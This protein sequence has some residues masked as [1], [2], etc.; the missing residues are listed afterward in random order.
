LP[1]ANDVRADGI[2]NVGQRQASTL[3]GLEKIARRM[4]LS[5][6][7]IFVHELPPTMTTR[8]TGMQN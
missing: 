4:D 8:W 7:R 5:F 6:K 1:E 3:A 2:E